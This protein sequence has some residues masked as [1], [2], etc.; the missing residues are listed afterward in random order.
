[1][2]KLSRNQRRRKKPVNDES[3]LA[4]LGSTETELAKPSTVRFA[5]TPARTGSATVRCMP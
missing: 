4:H 1:M 2:N 3:T 5:N